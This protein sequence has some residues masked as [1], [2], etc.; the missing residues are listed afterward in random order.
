MTVT[1]H[2]A[3]PARLTATGDT[4]LTVEQDT[5]LEHAQAAALVLA[6]P[7]GALAD[8]PQFGTPDQ[9]FAQGGADETVMSDALERWEPR[10]PATIQAQAIQDR[11]QEVDVTVRGADG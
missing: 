3:W 7:T 1:P 10:I 9:V 4:F 2:L 5:P 11:I 8:N 6:T